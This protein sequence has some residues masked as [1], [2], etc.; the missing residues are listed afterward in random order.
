MPLITEEQLDIAYKT[1]KSFSKGKGM[2]PASGKTLFRWKKTT[3]NH[4]ANAGD[5]ANF[6]VYK[7]IVIATFPA[8]YKRTSMYDFLDR[9][10]DRI[11]EFKNYINKRQDDEI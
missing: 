10:W 5:N 11:T 2:V 7:N 6:L 4:M 9:H 8:K 3:F 1:Y